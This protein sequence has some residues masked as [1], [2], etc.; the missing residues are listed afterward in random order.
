MCKK[1]SSKR[2]K[3]VPFR[4]LQKGISILQSLSSSFS[5]QSCKFLFYLFFIHHLSQLIVTRK[6]S[7]PFC[8]EPIKL[9]YEIEIEI[10][11][12]R[13][14]RFLTK[15]ESIVIDESA[16]KKNSIFWCNFEFPPGIEK[17]SHSDIDVNHAHSLSI[18]D[19]MLRL[20]LMISSWG[21][22]KSFQRKLNPRIRQTMCA[23]KSLG[24]SLSK[25]FLELTLKITPD[26][27]AISIY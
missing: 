27:V 14:R 8:R 12:A 15:R 4:I 19:E 11:W 24:N 6:S 17:P 23:M 7:L 25:H 20:E 1:R 16:E 3:K 5:F 13:K 9:N 21:M 18:G 10:E 22:R 2:Q 26:L